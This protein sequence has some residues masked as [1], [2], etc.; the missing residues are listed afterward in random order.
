MRFIYCL[1]CG[2]LAWLLLLPVASPALPLPPRRL[3]ATGQ[4]SAGL[5]HALLVRPN[6]QLY[7][8][9][10]NSEGQLGDPASATSSLFIKRVPVAVSPGAIPAGTRFVQVSG[11]QYHSLALAAN[12]MLYAWGKNEYGQLGNNT[13]TNSNA[14]VAV[15]LGAAPAGT[16]FVWVSAG[17]SHSLALAADGTLYAWGDNASGQLGTGTTINSSAPVAVR[18]GA[19]PAGT[20]F[21]QVSAG[22]NYS[23]ALAADGMLY[24]WGHNPNGELGNNTTTDSNAPVAVSLGAAPA[25]TRFVQVRAGRYHALALAADGTAYAW[26]YNASG[27]LGNG[28][29]SS[30][31]VPVA[32]RLG[33]APVGTRFVQLSAG[34]DH[35][36][37]LAADG[38][39]YAWG[40]NYYG[41]LGNYGTANS[42]VPVAVSPGAVPAGT[43]FAQVSAGDNYSLAL[44]ADGTP[45]AWGYNTSGQL[46]N[47]GSISDRTSSVPVAVL[48]PAATGYAQAAAGGNHSLGLRTNGTLYA[49][50]YNAYGQLGNDAT[51]D[52]PWPVA[53]RLGA[54]PAGTRFGQVSA[55]DIHSLVLAADGTAY[56]WGYNGMGQLGNNTTAN[57][58]VPVAVSAPAGVLFTQVS[59]GE[60]HSLALAADGTLYAWGDN[61][62]GQLG[63]GSTTASLVPAPVSAGAIPAGTRFVQV[64]AGLNYSLALAADGTIYGWGYNSSGQL[65]NGATTA[66]LVP[67]AASLGAAPAGTRFVQVS[68]GMSHVLGLAAD[69]TLYAWGNNAFDQLG[70][71]GSANA[72]PLPVAVSTPTGVRFTQVS[73]G[74][75]HSLGLAADGTLYAW[76][77]NL[78]GQMGN[79]LFDYSNV[80]VAESSGL[81]QWRGVAAGS[82]A[83]HSL[84]LGAEAAIFSA[85]YN[86]EG[87][88][89]DGTTTNSPTFLRS[90]APLPVQLSAFT[91]QAAGPAAVLLAWVTASEVNS[92]Y[93]AVERSLDGINFSEVARQPAA[94]T[95]AIA[96]TY[97]YRDATLPAGASILYYRLRQVDRDGT[98]AYSPVRPV[99]LA[100][101]AGL[102]LYPNPAQPGTTHTGAVPGAA[103]QVLDGLGRLVLTTQADAT[104]AAPLALPPGLA[105]G[106]YLVRTGPQALRLSVQ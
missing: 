83:Y 104:G 23:L 20:R 31:K 33:A 94:G 50:G 70:N 44:A 66:S 10:D 28:S 61:R 30:S 90:Q 6:G 84:I 8:W 71:G 47:N 29:R 86:G 74:G 9:G 85:G 46:G 42:N 39:L 49:W 4:L 57:S 65:G 51:A 78:Y 58:P 13:T 32:V 69:G 91:A 63:N 67:V 79:S 36:L 59:A 93:F 55:G 27:Q 100:G 92:A 68:A 38:T 77:D 76:G 22:S 21:V 24:A 56:A 19:T 60:L 43:R 99:A 54:A 15:S 14:P 81:T 62:L 95:S 98:T 52:S 106:V 88:L 41:Q 97:S 96:R 18:P 16:R 2:L 103:V 40:Y 1:C 102:A 35:S 34:S 82:T 105:P 72:N 101:A 75:L 87:E 12:G 64:S 89:G 25:G 45:Y 80:P 5:Y 37:A 7:A 26:G 11:G 3:P 48:A 53:V 17:A 73:A